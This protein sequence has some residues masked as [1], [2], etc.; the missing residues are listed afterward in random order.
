MTFCQITLDTCCQSIVGYFFCILPSSAV[1]LCGCRTKRRARSCA[2][3]AVFIPQAHV[4]VN[5]SR[6]YRTRPQ[7]DSAPREA[8]GSHNFIMKSPPP[9]SSHS[10]NL[11]PACR[12]CKHI[13]RVSFSWRPATSKHRSYQQVLFCSLQLRRR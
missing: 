2:L 5:I 11:N 13:S 12:S 6:T 8:T 4:R 7:P 9:S 1:V 10:V 3:F